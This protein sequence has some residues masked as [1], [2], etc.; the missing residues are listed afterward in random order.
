MNCGNL[1]DSALLF[2][3]VVM[4]MLGLSG[5]VLADARSSGS[6]ANYDFSPYYHKESLRWAGLVRGTR[7]DTPVFAA[8]TGTQ[9]KGKLTFNQQAEVVAEADGRLKIRTFAVGEQP[10]L[11]G[12]VSR[13]DMLCYNVP[14]KGVSGLEMKFFIRTGTTARDEEKEPP[15]VTVYQ[16]PDLKTCVGGAGNCRTGASRFHMYFVFD[17]RDDAVL[18]GDRFRLED[19]DKLLGWVRRSDGFIWN[20]AFGLRPREDLRSPDGASNGTICSYEKLNDAVERNPLTCSPVEGGIDWFKS[21][22]R[23]PVLD[24]VDAKGKH[25]EPDQ[26]SASGDKRRFYQVALARPGLVGRPLGDGR[27]AINAGLAQQILPEMKSLSSKKNVD[28]FFLLDGTAS[29]EAV[30]DAV[31]GTA[32]RRGVIQEI[33]HRLKQVPGFRSTQFRFGFRVYRDSYADKEKPGP[34]DGVGEG[35]PLPEQCEL[36]PAEQKQEFVRFQQA[37]STVTTTAGDAA[38][39]YEENLYGGLEQSL[40]SDMKSCADHLKVMFVIGDNGYKSRM[41]VMEGGRLVSKSKYKNEVSRDTLVQLMRGSSSGEKTNNVVPFFI[42]TPRRPDTAKHPIAYNRAYSRFESQSKQILGDSL[43]AG[44]G[45]VN[46]HF[47]RMGESRLVQRLTTQVAKL[48]SSALI[49]EIILDIRGG[50]AL[51][52]VIDRLK[53]ERVDIPGVYWHILEKGACGELGDQCHNRIFDTTLIGYVEADE[54]VVEELWVTSNSLSSWIRILGGFEGYFELP[55][56]Q[57]RKALISALIL[58]LQQEIRRP[59]ID[60]SGET[61]AEYAQRR[62]GLPVRWHSPLL[63]YNVNALSAEYVGRD[64]QGTQIVVDANGKPILDR[65]KQTVPAV[66]ICELRHLALWAIKSKQMLEVV[67]RENYRPVFEAGRFDSQRCPDATA[68]GKALM[69]I[70]GP[71]GSEALG[72]DKDYRYG[73]S[74]GGRRGYWIPQ[75]YLP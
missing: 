16:D 19:D 65:N 34:G 39:D 33:I 62:G 54:K 2:G 40:K 57:L 47:F 67:E 48:S 8:D 64:K 13:S 30:I 17:Q 50:A 4:I 46:E 29:M 27:V 14:V 1:K 25:V 5:T 45:Q 42:Q 55:E 7:Q 74:Y 26:V 73:H 41:A 18:L 66:P 38:D 71:V 10:E 36:S 9:E 69:R 12:W 11:V 51:G 37:I 35:Y 52:T 49:D 3:A 20:N 58:G 61:P 44:Q 53:R 32:Q 59:P 43:P 56:P 21:P 75:E 15:T 23:V 63:S 24:L 70:S 72:P 60:V 6:C 28:V 22:V 31:R 68:N